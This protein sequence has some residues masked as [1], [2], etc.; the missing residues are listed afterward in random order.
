MSHFG[1]HVRHL[2]RRPSKVAPA[3]EQDRQ[4]AERLTKENYGGRTRVFDPGVGLP[5][6]HSPYGRH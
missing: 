2:L 1:T 5:P 6:D 3:E 4:A